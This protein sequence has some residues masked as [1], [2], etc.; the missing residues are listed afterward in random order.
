AHDRCR[1]PRAPAVHGLDP[2]VAQ[3]V[4]GQLR[5]AGVAGEPGLRDEDLH[6]GRTAGSQRAFPLGSSAIRS[7][8]TR[9]VWPI[10]TFAGSAS[11]RIEKTRSP[12]IFTIA[13]TRGPS[14]PVGNPTS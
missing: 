6:A 3:R 13:K 12:S 11:I 1:R 5:A 9:T 10:A 2:G 7:G 14:K 4:S 8:V